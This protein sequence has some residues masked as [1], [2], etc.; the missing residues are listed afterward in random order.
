M[1]DGAARAVLAGFIAGYAF[2]V[3]FTAIA[4]VLL[5][6]LRS[7]VSLLA[8]A[9]SPALSPWAVA[10][11]VSLFTFL[12]W[13]LIGMVWGLVFYGLEDIA[14]RGGL[15]SPNLAFTLV[16]VG[17][18]AALGA[19]WVRLLRPLRRPLVSL[20]VVYAALFGWGLPHLIA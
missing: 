6:R 3:V 15:G 17:S 14:P 7:Q 10:V 13:T 2:A 9:I 8:V 4:A 5:V 11:P 19:P 12:V 20:L 1:N 16:L 18:A